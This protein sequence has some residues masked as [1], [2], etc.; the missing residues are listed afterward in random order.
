M[1]QSFLSTRYRDGCLTKDG[2][3]IR[4]R[5]VEEALCSIG[6]MMASLGSKDHCL[7]A[8]NKLEYH[9]SQQLSGWKHD[10]PAP[11]HVKPVPFSLV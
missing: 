9:L 8:P 11:S 3:P 4:S 2:E 6:Q 1:Q 7:I 5:T 10:D